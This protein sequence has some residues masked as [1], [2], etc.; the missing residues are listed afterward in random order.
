MAVGGRGE[1]VHQGEPAG[2]AHSAV[3]CQAP[4]MLACNANYQTVYGAAP[5]APEAS[6]PA[7]LTLAT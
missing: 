3:S 4:S 2:C 7:I 1:T 6:Q 5:G